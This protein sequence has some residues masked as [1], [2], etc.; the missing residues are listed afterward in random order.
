M[1]KNRICNYNKNALFVLYTSHFLIIFLNK[2]LVVCVTFKLTFI[3]KYFN[4][5]I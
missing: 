5:N 3:L 1:S 4:E 2:K